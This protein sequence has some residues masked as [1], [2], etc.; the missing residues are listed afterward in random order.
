[1]RRL[2]YA[3]GALL[4][5]PRAAA[6][7]QDGMEVLVD[8]VGQQLGGFL[9]AL[10]A[11]LL[12]AL[13]VAFAVTWGL[14]L[15][16]EWRFRISGGHPRPASSTGIAFVL[17]TVGFWT[18][19][20]LTEEPEFFFLPLGAIIGI[21]PAM[22]VLAIEVA[23]N[24]RFPREREP[25][26]SLHGRGPRAVQSVARPGRTAL[27]VAVVATAVYLARLPPA[28]V[29]WIWGLTLVTESVFRSRGGRPRPAAS[30]VI[31]YA[32]FSVG[33][34][35]FFSLRWGFGLEVNFLM[36]SARAG[37][38]P[39]TLV[40]VAEVA[41]SGVMERE[42]HLSVDGQAS[43]DPDEVLQVDPRRGEELLE[44]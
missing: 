14:A 29:I 34:F 11:A 33:F 2:A 37:L 16:I 20:A 17:F 19:F 22:L 10:F 35:T 12:T 43:P 8:W 23:R 5:L 41:R 31:A 6:A 40:L 25:H 30:T 21:V 4:L 39:A 9:S 3:S 36:F 32:L 28:T 18:F 27:I 13:A 15:L 42:A 7:R 44:G 24:R 1:M 26:P 38:L